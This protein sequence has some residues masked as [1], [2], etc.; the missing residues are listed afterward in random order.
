MT[1]R[2]I[3]GWDAFE[4]EFK[5][6][7]NH[8]VPSNNYNFETYDEEWE[9]IKS[10]DPHYV[11]TWVDGD[12]SSLLVA[13]VAWVNRIS[14][15]VC[16]IPWQDDTDYEVILSVEVE[17]ECYSEDEDVMES[18]NGEYGDPDCQICEG[19]GYRTEYVEE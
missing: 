11:W 1:Y 4:K 3:L 8:L 14:Y 15:H 2:Q 10:L 7:Q 5:P 16:E 12:M 9:Y 6:K 13:G 17:C 19:Y 18:R